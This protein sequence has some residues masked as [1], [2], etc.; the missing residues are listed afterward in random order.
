MWKKKQYFFICIIIAY[1]TL[2][3]F[4]TSY[5]KMWWYVNRLLIIDIG[6]LSFS[7]I[8]FSIFINVL[9]KRASVYLINIAI[10]LNSTWI[11]Y[12]WNSLNQGGSIL[13][14][15]VF[16]SSI[17]SMLINNLV[18]KY[19]ELNVRKL[20]KDFIFTFSVGGAMLII[21]YIV[22]LLSFLY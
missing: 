19:N 12:W 4:I 7:I 14:L 2:Y 21:T 3:T 13:L 22:L 10:L 8:L 15:Y 16:T 6:I 1:W 9:N 11:M 5:S 20:L 18:L 17:I